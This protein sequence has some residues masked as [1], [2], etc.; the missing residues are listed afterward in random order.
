MRISELQDKMR[1]SVVSDKATQPQA[2]TLKAVIM[3]TEYAKLK[4]E[5]EDLKK[6]VKELKGE[7]SE[8]GDV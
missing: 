6:E 5:I 1:R 2:E 3:G 7:D 4:N 8:N